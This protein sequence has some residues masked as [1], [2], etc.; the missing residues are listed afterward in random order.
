MTEKLFRYADKGAQNKSVNK[1]MLISTAIL[2]VFTFIVIIVSY[3]MG[4]QS[5]TYTI[6]SGVVMA[7]AC[8]GG[9]FFYLKNKQ[10]AKIRYFMLIFLY[11]ISIMII[12]GFK[13]YYMRFLAVM[14]FLCCILFY[15]TKF[16][17][18]VA[19]IISAVNIIVTLLR[20]YV[21]KN[22]NADEW[23]TN[24]VASLVVCAL[25]FVM[26]Y[27]TKLGKR[28]ND[29]SLGMVQSN[30]EKQKEM[31]DDVI[32]IA[33]DVRKGTVSAMDIVNELQSSS[34]IVHR[35]VYDISEST[36]HTAESIENQ[37]NMTQNIQESLANTVVRVDNMVRVAQH[38]HELNEESA[39]Q[40]RNL[41]AEA[42]ELARIN[43]TVTRSMKQ[44][45]QNVENV[46]AITQ[47]IFSIS[48]QTN[49]LALNASIES[50]RAGEA[51]RGFAVVADQIRGLSEKTR[52]ETENISN[53]LDALAAN[54]N[55]TAKAVEES[56]ANGNNQ[57]KMI[58][59]VAKQV[60]DMNENVNQ[61][62]TDVEEIK[63][64]I[65][66][67][68]AANTEIV[69]NISTLSAVSEEVTASA[70]QST[71]IT[72]DNFKNAKEAKVF[73]ESILEVSHKIDK[74]L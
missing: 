55:E 17:N 39:A 44:L 19:V 2:N 31:L 18:I 41:R 35:S 46:K 4:N 10:S 52:Q 30:A 14:P 45:Q 53:I 26:A 70:Q 56:L 20:Q 47:T 50:A 54:A 49:L 3:T 15:D 32:A 74:Y 62:V 11:M 8:L 23:L 34:E 38:S 21:W 6:W 5:L 71:A 22:Y 7:I 42:E 48:N 1:F 58:E 51:G 69:D 73:L 13:D 24:S 28:F 68:S 72:D 27:M 33:E 67:L 16:S 9:L 29:D 60:E 66:D 59:Q 12:Y 43:E 57:E 36:I 37:S 61:L 63:V 65:D 64:V 25:M 40:M